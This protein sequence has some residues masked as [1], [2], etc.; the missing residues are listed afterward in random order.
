MALWLLGSRGLLLKCSGLILPPPDHQPCKHTHTHTS[1]GALETLSVVVPHKEGSNNNKHTHRD[2]S[3]SIYLTFRTARQA[4]VKRGR[5]L[6]ITGTVTCQF[7][8]LHL[9]CG[10]RPND[11]LPLKHGVSMLPAAALPNLSTITHHVGTLVVRPVAVGGNQ[12]QDG[13]PFVLQYGLLSDATAPRTLYVGAS[14][15]RSHE[16]F[17]A[18]ARRALEEVLGSGDEDE[19]GATTLV[20]GSILPVISEL[21]RSAD[22]ATHA[23]HFF[24]GLQP[25]PASS[26]DGEDETTEDESDDSGDEEGEEREGEV[27]FVWRT[28]DQLRAAAKARQK[29]ELVRHVLPLVSKARRALEEAVRHGALRGPGWDELHH[30]LAGE[31]EGEE[32]H[33]HVT[34][35]EKVS[36]LLA[37]AKKTAM[38][39]AVAAGGECGLPGVLPVTVLSGFLGSG[40]TTLLKHILQTQT[41][42]KARVVGRSVGRSCPDSVGWGAQGHEGVLDFLTS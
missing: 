12:D 3:A 11:L 42:M 41:G 5:F 39:A 40:K 37:E 9:L 7:G 20:S 4:D 8:S 21:Q 36:A 26:V 18:A 22:G 10:P 27:A 38:A 24:L 34:D 32:G 30:Y 33:D 23:Y 28:H 14:V 6:E 1:L 29:R 16:S 25:P 35:H 17:P 2:E 13:P 31:E 19:S 15:P